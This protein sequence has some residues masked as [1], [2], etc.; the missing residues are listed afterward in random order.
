MEVVH[1][2]LGRD[3]LGVD[4][5]RRALG[6]ERRGVPEQVEH[7]GARRG[8]RAHNVVEDAEER[9]LRWAVGQ[10]VRSGLR[11]VSEREKKG[12]THLHAVQRAAQT[13]ARAVDVAAAHRARLGEV[14]QW[15]GGLR[16]T[17]IHQSLALRS[18]VRAETGDKREE[19]AN[20]PHR[21]GRR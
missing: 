8:R 6:V 3:R 7:G 15:E 21:Q 17:R 5:H 13:G 10:Q 18:A 9:V 16:P 2:A 14:R 11:G 12:M 19:R 4:L 20:A 1:E